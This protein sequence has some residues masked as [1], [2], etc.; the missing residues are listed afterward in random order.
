MNTSTSWYVLTK[1]ERKKAF[2]NCDEVYCTSCAFEFVM[3]AED[4]KLCQ[5]CLDAASEWENP[6]SIQW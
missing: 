2:D 4:Q 6:D 5:N 1:K 3:D